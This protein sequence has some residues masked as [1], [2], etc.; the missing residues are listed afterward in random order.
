MKA[1]RSGPGS[2]PSHKRSDPFAKAA[3]L[4]LAT[5]FALMASGT[6]QAAPTNYDAEGDMTI[7]QIASSVSVDIDDGSI[8]TP[9]QDTCGGGTPRWWTGD[10]FTFTS[11]WFADNTAG[12]QSM[13]VGY[14]L[15]LYQ[16]DHG[17]AGSLIDS[18]EDVDVT[19]PLPNPPAE[20]G[21]R[22]GTLTVT[23]TYTG[24]N[25]NP[26]CEDSF[27]VYRHAGSPDPN[28][29]YSDWY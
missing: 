15:E 6:A 24:W 13:D 22:S 14:T 23:G 7:T 16:W 18:D 3:A 25:G 4:L 27:H 28:N 26:A 21:T 10:T 29:A 2:G 11:D 19:V 17:M 1:S 5:A 9:P 8:T 20:S 12:T